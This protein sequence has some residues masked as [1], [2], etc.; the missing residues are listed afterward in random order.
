MALSVGIASR[1]L[2]VVAS[3]SC[4]GVTPGVDHLI[5]CTNSTTNRPSSILVS[6]AKA[7]TDHSSRSARL[8]EALCRDYEV[9]GFDSAADG[10]EA[11]RHRARADHRADQQ[12]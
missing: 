7:G 1:R 12:G 10:D 6:P 11:F 3:G 4:G 5:V 8:C 2:P 9:L